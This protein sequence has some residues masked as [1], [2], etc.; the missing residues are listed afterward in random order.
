MLPLPA[1]PLLLLCLG[2]S[3]SA[4]AARDFTLVATV[5][6]AEILLG[7]ALR[8][9]LRF[10]ARILRLFLTQS[11]V[12][13]GLYLLRFGP[14]AGAALTGLRVSCQIALA[15]APGMM[16]LRSVPHSQMMRSLNRVM[17]STAAFVLATSLRFMPMLRKELRSIFEAQTLRGARISPADLRH[18]RSWPDFVHCLLVPFIV[19][20]FKIAEEIAIAAKIRNFGASSKRTFWPGDR[21]EGGSRDR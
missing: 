10:F 4:F 13:V 18:P 21:E 12:I 17:P 16:A 6:G 7:L 14:E 3:V 15:L 1:G 20:C 11:L 8:S 19:Q 2:L 5:T 9:G